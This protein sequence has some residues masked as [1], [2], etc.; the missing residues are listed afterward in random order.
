MFGHF[1]FAFPDHFFGKRGKFAL[2]IPGDQVFKFPPGLDGFRLIPVNRADLQI[3]AHADL[4]QGIGNVFTGGIQHQK[5]AI[6]IFGIHILLIAEKRI[7]NAQFGQ[8]GH[9]MKRMF[10]FQAGIEFPRFFVAAVLIFLRSPRV[11]GFGG[12]THRLLFLEIR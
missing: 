1:L 12:R 8:S 11:K 7:G 3:M 2:R 5:I 10:F 6:G 9:F 4:I